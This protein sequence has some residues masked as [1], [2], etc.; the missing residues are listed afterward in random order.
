MNHSSTTSGRMYK[1]D[2]VTGSIIEVPEF[3]QN[4]ANSNLSQPDFAACT[5]LYKD[6]IYIYTTNGLIHT[7]NMQTHEYSSFDIPSDANYHYMFNEN[8]ALNSR[9]V[10]HRA[11]VK[12][13]YQIGK[14]YRKDF[15]R[16]H[17]IMYM[18]RTRKIINFFR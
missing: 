5:C 9:D 16:K 3:R 7:Y 8:S 15:A 14:R 6:T 10:A 1:F 18:W 4:Q 13:Q 11:R 2:G 17:K 12:Q